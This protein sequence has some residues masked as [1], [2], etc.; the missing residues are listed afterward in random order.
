M[1][2][3]FK[4]ELDPQI[5]E[6]LTSVDGE[7]GE[8]APNLDSLLENSKSGNKKNQMDSVERL[9][10]ITVIEEKSKPFFNDKNFYKSAISGEGEQTKRVHDFL[11][12]FL[13]AKDP[14]DK[15]MFRARLIPAF[16]DLASSISGKIGQK[17]PLCKILL[18]RFGLLSPTMIS[19]IQQDILRRIIFNNNTGLSIY[20]MDEWLKK[21]SA[22]VVTLSAT[23]ELKRVKKDSNQKI[24]D[25]VD[26]TKGQRESEMLF[27]KNKLT[28]RNTFEIQLVQCLK[29]IMNHP[30]QTG[31][32]GLGPP[33]DGEQR[34]SIGSIGE[35][36]RKLNNIDK[37]ITRAYNT[38]QNLE[39]HIDTLSKKADGVQASAID[40]SQVISEFNTIRQMSKL[41][42]G[43]K[44]NHFPI[45]MKHYM[46]PNIRDLG[47]RE[48]IINEMAYVESLDAGLF[49]R[50]YK[51][52]TT[53][54]IP[55]IIILPNYGERGIC[56]EPF[57]R[58]NRATSKGRIAIPLYPKNL[59]FAV[60]SACADLR[61]QV[62]KEKA[63]HYWM[64]EGITGR[65]YQWFQDQKLRGDVKEYF[66]NDYI[67]WITKESAGT[68]KLDRTVR[69]IFWRLMPFPQE[70][71]DKLR[72]RGYVYNEL[73][74]KDINRSRSDGY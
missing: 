30:P 62:A 27:L 6:L 58:K 26:H 52:Q 64:E 16:W 10:R 48:N 54:I 60:I 11:T 8:P 55:N 47:I 40:S 66:I 32:D 20:Y 46:R 39:Q 9:K 13:N 53:R 65:Y 33:Y 50:T 35:I 74:K 73:Y 14:Q 7:N 44:G 2:E 29:I 28:Q 37:D 45:L 31:F 49:L 21:I 56:W 36:I 59:R 72:N 18:L 12:R 42:V 34:R 67:L 5:A 63:L 68:Q 3:N 71:K 69:G 51:N 4:G 19:P 15:S 61:W 1:A 70:L 57:E 24:L 43:R 22:G 23:D 41:C 25:K 17:L 38:L